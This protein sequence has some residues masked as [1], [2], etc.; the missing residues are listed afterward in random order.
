MSSERI[1][2]DVVPHAA[3]YGA[4]N[5]NAFDGLLEFQ[6]A[7][8]DDPMLSQ[9]FFRREQQPGRLE[10]VIGFIKC[11]ALNVK[12]S[13]RW[14]EHI[15]LQVGQGDFFSSSLVSVFDSAFIASQN[16][17]TKPADHRDAPPEPTNHRR[18]RGV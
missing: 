4:R 6:A 18:A 9:A 16:D 2:Q 8:H 3:V 15:V 17:A 13:D 11:G 10:T 5:L 7:F 14:H 1:P 12:H